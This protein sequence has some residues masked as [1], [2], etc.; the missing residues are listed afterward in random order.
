[1]NLLP[2]TLPSHSF[3]VPVPLLYPTR[4]L[5]KKSKTRIH[6]H[7]HTYTYMR[8]HSPSHLLL[9][10]SYIPA[11]RHNPREQSLL[12]LL[13]TRSSVLPLLSTH[14]YRYYRYYYYRSYRETNYDFTIP[15]RSYFLLFCY[16]LLRG[17]RFARR[18]QPT[19]QPTNQPASQPTKQVVIVAAATV[20]CQL[21]ASR[22]V[23]SSTPILR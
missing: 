11:S 3:K 21:I 7:T 8:L 22:C 19:S 1:M 14:H 17:T 4:T 10:Y 15:L 12:P 23:D 20:F 16:P 5:K 13:P 9:T 6:T 18:I 2:P